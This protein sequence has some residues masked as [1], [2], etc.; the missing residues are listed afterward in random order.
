MSLLQQRLNR[1]VAPE[2]VSMKPEQK[3]TAPPPRCPACCSRAVRRAGVIERKRVRAAQL[4]RCTD[5]GKTFF[6]STTPRGRSPNPTPEV[7]EK[8]L[9]LRRA[10]SWGYLR[11]GRAL[12]LPRTTVF[13]MCNQRRAQ[14]QGTFTI[15]IRRPLVQS[16][17]EM[18]Q[19]TNR[20]PG[21][22]S[23]TLEQFIAELLE[24]CI[25]E[26]RA[27][28]NRRMAMTPLVTPPPKAAETESAKRL[29]HQRKLSAADIL[30]SR[31]LL[32]TEGLRQSAVATWY[33]V[34]QSTVARELQNGNGRH[35]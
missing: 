15:S 20:G 18:F 11:I 30:K 29:R 32:T 19:N 16:L 1:S 22:S 21:G 3:P 4:W 17:E 10:R 33:G 8:V 24:I 28:Q 14:P 7:R 2:N 12:G 6:D 9:F 13:R 26:F 25:V 34:A 31:E 35:G 23:S 27:T 5:C